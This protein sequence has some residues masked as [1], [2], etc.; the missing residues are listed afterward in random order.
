MKVG[1]K[2]KVEP[3]MQ[4]EDRRPRRAC[5]WNPPRTFAGGA[6]QPGQGTWHSQRS[7]WNCD[8]TQ[9]TA[10]NGKLEP[11]VSARSCAYLSSPQARA[12]RDRRAVMLRMRAELGTT[13]QGLRALREHSQGPLRVPIPAQTSPRLVDL[14]TG[15][16]EVE[17]Y[18]S[19]DQNPMI[20]SHRV[21]NH[22]K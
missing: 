14:N 3:E 13:I 7:G 1:R 18:H 21:R 20:T 15:R 10:A 9:G 8:V 11:P 17:T 6:H 19:N 4:L 16:R 12:G 5:C 22:L 2:T